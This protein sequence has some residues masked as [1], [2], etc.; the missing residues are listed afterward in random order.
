MVTQLTRITP[1]QAGKNAAVMYF[2]G[3]FVF[4]LF[5]ILIYVE[6]GPE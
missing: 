2:I 4:C 3:G 6:S 1:L 5:G